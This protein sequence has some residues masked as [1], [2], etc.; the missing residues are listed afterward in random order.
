[1]DKLTR[2]KKINALVV[3]D[4]DANLPK[5]EGVEINPAFTRG[6]KNVFGGFKASEYIFPGSMAKRDDFIK[7]INEEMRR[8]MKTIP[9]D[10]FHPLTSDIFMALHEGRAGPTPEIVVALAGVARI[11]GDERASFAAVGNAAAADEQKRRT[12]MFYATPEGAEIAKE[13]AQAAQK[14]QEQ[15]QASQAQRE[16]QET[17]RK[18]ELQRREQELQ[19]LQEAAIAG[20]AVKAQQERIE[21]E[22]LREKRAAQALLHEQLRKDR[23]AADALRIEN[24]QKLQAQRLLDT[25]NA[26]KAR[27][28]GIVQGARDVV[29]AK[30]VEVFAGEVEAEGAALHGQQL[31]KRRKATALRKLVV[32]EPQKQADA[33]AAAAQE[34]EAGR[35]TWRATNPKGFEQKRSFQEMLE[36][37][38]AKGEDFKAFL[39]DK[40]MPEW[41]NMSQVAFC[42]LLNTNNAGKEGI[43]KPTVTDTILS[44][45]RAGK[46]S[47]LRDSVDVITHAFGMRPAENE[48]MSVHEKMLWKGIGGHEF[49]WGEEK[50]VAA[51]DTAIK[52][53][54]KTGDTGRLVSELIDSS[55]IRFERLRETLNVQ[56]LPQWKK[57]AK[58]EDTE[59]ALKFL[60]LVNPQATEV[61][62]VGEAAAGHAGAYTVSR[63]NAGLL[64]LVMGREFVVDTAIEE[65]KKQGNPG[66][67]MFLAMTGRAG[68]VSIRPTE[69]VTQFNAAGLACTEERVKK[70]RT[71]TQ[72]QRGGGITEP[73]AKAII[74]MTEGSAKHLT[75]LGVY[76]PM[77]AEQKA[78]ALD[79]LT[80]VPHPK[81]MLASALK[82]ELPIGKL[83]E[84]TCDRLGILHVGE[85]SFCEQVGISHMSGFVTGKSSLQRD[86]AEKMAK[87]F[88]AK[89]EFTKAEEDQFIALATGL[90]VKR[91][92]DIILEEVKVGLLGR[93]EGLRQIYDFSNLPRPELALK[94]GVPYHA[95][96]YS[97]TETSGGRII[98]SPEAIRRIGLASG[99]TEAAIGDFVSVYDGK[100]VARKEAQT[101][102]GEGELLWTEQMLQRAAKSGGSSGWA[103]AKT[104]GPASGTGDAS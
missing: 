3:A 37:S 88:A 10:P 34:R 1:M 61:P 5:V 71:G 91:T 46:T 96:Q 74:A 69:I 76:T 25:E 24:E 94:A 28:A 36:E 42:E 47:P 51:I 50:G 58:I 52:E 78:E 40:V 100:Q 86:T 103:R 29:E 85:G 83:V 8:N 97:V 23:E 89:Y 60:R 79:V 62:L 70:M 84:K 67:A 54:R 14:L 22:Q 64:S 35:E 15:Q 77:T 31:E 59:M 7:A 44:S 16:Q 102:A 33:S 56:Q 26:E 20:R 45:W 55:G 38:H 11:Y 43:L 19:P 80:S 87:W 104:D 32:E 73:Y 12:A 65:A 63:Q 39:F 98:E 4:I 99:V 92:P 2:Q 13:D 17:Q 68:A 21:D 18:L 41:G 49:T 82:K 6:F 95:V 30:R 93:V 27:V 81:K 53:T 48:L 101:P 75:A 9:A 90:D 66:G 72:M 57:G